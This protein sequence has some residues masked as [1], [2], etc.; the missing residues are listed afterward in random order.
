MRS[1]LL[2]SGLRMR[3]QLGRAS[4][5]HHLPL[6]DTLE[7]ASRETAGAPPA[8]RMPALVPAGASSPRAPSPELDFDPGQSFDDDL[9]AA[10]AQP[11]APAAPPSRCR[12]RVAPASSDS[13]AAA[14][15]K[16]NP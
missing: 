15:Q 13:T 14:L 11:A 3:Q 4:I 7:R 10:P 1:L 6:Q 9:A 5:S 12:A 2:Q 16:R 8:Q